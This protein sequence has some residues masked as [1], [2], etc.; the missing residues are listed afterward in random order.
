MPES[1]IPNTK[2]AGVE[3]DPVTQ[4]IAALLYPNAGTY[5]SGFEATRFPNNWFDLAI[6]N[7]PFGD[8]GVHDAAFKGARRFLR[9]PIHTYFFAKA[10]DK[11]RPGGIVA[12]ITSHHTMDGKVPAAREYLSKE[13]KFLGAIRLP[14]TAFEKN[15]TLQQGYY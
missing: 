12:F 4:R 14:Q 2:L 6:S 13:A 5:A 11:V 1:L 8:Y 7:V 9:Y 3:L 10:L 15:N